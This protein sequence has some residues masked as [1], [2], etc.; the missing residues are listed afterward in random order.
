M[1]VGFAMTTQRTG[2]IDL[3]ARCP[4]GLV[5]TGHQPPVRVVRAQ[6]TALERDTASVDQRRE[7]GSRPA[8]ASYRSSAGWRLAH[9]PAL[10]W[11]GCATL[12]VDGGILGTD[13]GPPPAAVIGLR[14]R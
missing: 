6:E 2:L 4:V 10:M 7:V 5:G 9:S 13:G 1:L 8:K 14:R 11:G 3:V 12:P